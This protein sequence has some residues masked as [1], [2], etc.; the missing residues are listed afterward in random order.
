MITYG[1]I[2]QGMEK[3]HLSLQPH[4]SKLLIL[5]PH[6]PSPLSWC[7][8]LGPKAA[9]MTAPGKC[10]DGNGVH[11]CQL[12]SVLAVSV[13]ALK[14]R[15]W[16]PTSNFSC[17]V[18]GL[19]CLLGLW[20]VSAM[21]KTL[22]QSTPRTH[23]RYQLT[24]SLSG[25][26]Q[27][28]DTLKFIVVHQSMT[29]IDS[30][31]SW[32]TYIWKDTPSTYSSHSLLLLIVGLRY[33]WSSYSWVW[34][35]DMQDLCW[36]RLPSL[37]S[38]CCSSGSFNATWC[39]IALFVSARCWNVDQREITLPQCFTLLACAGGNANSRA[40]CPWIPFTPYHETNSDIGQT[41]CKLT[42]KNGVHGPV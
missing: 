12:V 29:S 24:A 22:V 4:L 35:G 7:R 26:L 6:P 30:N 40:T 9:A 20:P 11:C 32:S 37:S 38:D 14:E 2:K 31:Q 23:T 39:H 27:S 21:S 36:R 16:S 42:R 8:A 17:I 18:F 19:L 10:P 3:P 28:E 15:P 41:E 13:H 1:N 25:L 33:A 34:V 5:V